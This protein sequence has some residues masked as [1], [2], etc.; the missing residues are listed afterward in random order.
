MSPDRMLSATRTQRN[1]A[2]VGTSQLTPKALIVILYADLLP[3]RMS[4]SCL[5]RRPGHTQGTVPETKNRQVGAV[6]APGPLGTVM[7]WGR[8]VRH[9]RKRK[10]CENDLGDSPTGRCTNDVK[11]PFCWKSAEP[12]PPPACVLCRPGRTVMRPRASVAEAEASRDMV[13]GGVETLTATEGWVCLHLRLSTE[14]LAAEVADSFREII[15]THSTHQ[16]IRHRPAS[17]S[18]KTCLTSQ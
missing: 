16:Y 5:E 7:L 17:W 14:H 18:L 10:V 3:Q 6:T 2:C 13:R 15:S 9:S 12:R 1:G 11:E 4:V 8:R